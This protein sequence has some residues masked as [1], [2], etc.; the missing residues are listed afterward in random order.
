MEH[1]AQALRVAVQPINDHAPV[2]TSDGGGASAVINV[3]ENSTAVTTVTSTD[4]DGGAP[5]YTIVGEGSIAP[6]V[7]YD[8]LIVCFAE[9]TMILTPTGER[10]IES[11]RP[12]GPNGRTTGTCRRPGESTW[13]AAVRC[14]R[15]A[16]HR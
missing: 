3:V 6:S 14:W 4:V 2:I 11:L 7:L 12:G 9:G 10:P 1:A 8:D 13:G 15:R 5:S 16:S